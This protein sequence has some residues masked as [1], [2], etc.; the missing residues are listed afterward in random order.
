MH[1]ALARPDGQA[2]G[3]Q[4]GGGLTDADPR[5]RGV[6]GKTP[7]G[8]PPAAESEAEAERDD[9]HHDEQP[10]AEQPAAEERL[11]A[12]LVAAAAVFAVHDE[13]VDVLAGGRGLADPR[14]AGVVRVGRLRRCAARPPPVGRRGRV[15]VQPRCLGQ[16]ELLA[17]ITPV[18]PLG[19]GMPSRT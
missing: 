7:G 12:D 18:S 6:Q 3:G 4:H 16:A 9:Q 10:R 8:E 14:R 13:R 19:S 15:Q 1:L 11:A 5:H 17:L 2:V